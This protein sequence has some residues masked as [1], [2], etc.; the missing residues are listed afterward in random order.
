M[1]SEKPKRCCYKDAGTGSIYS[2]QKLN[3]HNECEIA[4]KVDAAKAF[5]IAAPILKGIRKSVKLS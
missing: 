5:E 2:A 1:N 4:L 3:Q